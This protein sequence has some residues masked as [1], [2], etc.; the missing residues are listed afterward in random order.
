MAGKKIGELTPLG[1][2][3]ISTDELELSLVGSTGSRKI[4]G[5]QLTNG[6]QPTLVS[7]TNIKTINTTSILGSGNLSVQPT[8]VSGTNIKTINGNTLL[9]SGNISAGYKFTNIVS[10]D[11]TN[12]VGG[13]TLTAIRSVLI[14]ANTL[15]NSM[16]EFGILFNG[17]LTSPGILNIF[18]YINTS[19]TLTGA[20]KIGQATSTALQFASLYMNKHYYFTATELFSYNRDNTTFSSGYAVDFGVTTSTLTLTSNLYLIFAIQQTGGLIS[21]GRAKNSIVKILS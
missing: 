13:S 16:L 12:V 7:G 17:Q 1:R 10:T 2:N 6:L 20:T 21:F 11:G 8:L 4:T 15:Q 19:D 9:G 5:A 18:A 3:L 14:P